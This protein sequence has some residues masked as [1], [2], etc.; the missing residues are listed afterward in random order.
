MSNPSQT[1]DLE[2]LYETAPCGYVSVSTAGRIVKANRT[3]AEWLGHPPGTLAGMPLHDILGFGGRIAY[4]T[5]LAPL[6]RMQGHVHEIALDLLTAGG[7]KVP[8]IANAAE[9]READGNH[10]FTR[11][12]LFR[13]VDRR[14]YERN[15]IEARDEAEAESNAHRQAALLREQFIAV[16]GHDLRNPLAALSAGVGLLGRK[17]QLSERGLAI[18]DEMD[19]SLGR[20]TTLVN[21]L[22]DLARGSLGSGFVVERIDTALTPALEQVVAEVRSIAPD[23]TIDVSICVD[24]PVYCDRG[25]LGQL[26]SN[27]LANAITHGTP[28]RPVT[29]DATTDG[30]LFTLSVANGGAPIPDAVMEHLFQPF[31]RGAIRPSRNG[32]GLGLYIASEIAK[33]HGGRIDVTSTDEETRFTFAM[34][35]ARPVAL[36]LE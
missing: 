26:A 29:F 23:R 24:D 5:H 10:R 1:E 32:L 19:G 34:M 28:D 21:D 12:T 22:L 20:A 25:R 18:L 36:S 13:A 7:E 16:L 9:K 27:L 14:I 4:E 35:K 11:L 2:D 8:T 3:I 6:L 17:E 31:F 33:A 30:D 15:L